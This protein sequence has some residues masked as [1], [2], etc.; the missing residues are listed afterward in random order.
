[1]RV[2]LAVIALL[3]V[4]L[5]GVTSCGSGDAEQTAAPAAGDKAVPGTLT[6]EGTTLDGKAFDASTLAGRPTVL[7]FWAPW[8]ATCFGQAASVAD[9]Q[10][11]HGTKVNLLGIAGL[12]K[13]AEMKQFVDEG[14]VGNVTHLNDEPGAVWKK[15]E[16]AEQSTYVLLDKNG[17]VLQKGWMDSLDFETKVAELAA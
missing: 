5:V 13:L 10:K 15:F 6:F 16:I 11:A 1:M 4:A 7:W 17:K 14:Q 3:A 12:G 9:M 2:R 8:C